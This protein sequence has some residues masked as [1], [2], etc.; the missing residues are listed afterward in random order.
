[1]AA[2]QKHRN[3]LEE[4]KCACD[5]SSVIL[6]LSSSSSSSSS[7]TSSSS[8]RRSKTF[9]R[10]PKDES[11]MTAKGK[12][13]S[14][15]DMVL[16]QEDEDYF[17]WHLLHLQSDFFIDPSTKFQQTRKGSTKQHSCHAG[18][19]EEEEREEEEY[20]FSLAVFVADMRKDADS[21]IGG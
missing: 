8:S 21:E 13:C 16:F 12:K 19:D 5:T 14:K 6:S 4:S 2:R 10:D 17:F 11:K 9:F 1:M 15:D 18:R 7:S 3:Q 20:R